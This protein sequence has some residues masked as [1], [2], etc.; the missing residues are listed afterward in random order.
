[1]TNTHYRRLLVR[2]VIATHACAVRTCSAE[3]FAVISSA[4]HGQ[5][6]GERNCRCR[7]SASSLVT[8]WC[9]RAFRNRNISAW[10]RFSIKC[11][12]E[13]L[14]SALTGNTP[15]RHR[16]LTLYGPCQ[17]LERAKMCLDNHFVRNITQ[18]GRSMQA[19]SGSQLEH[20]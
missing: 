7:V 10:S 6:A 19:S 8:A 17:T 14:P 2:R 5:D 4:T 13:A 1:M 11:L 3:V 12:K 18:T 15:C 16:A 20:Q 9:V